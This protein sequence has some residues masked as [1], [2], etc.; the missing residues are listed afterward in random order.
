MV[1]AATGFIACVG[2]GA[3]QADVL[4]PVPDV[5]PESTLLVRGT[6]D[7]AGALSNDDQMEIVSRV[8]MEFYYPTDRQARWLDPRPLAHLRSAA[9]DD[10][11]GSDPDF[12]DEAVTGA[13]NSRICVLAH[14]DFGCRGKAGGIVRFS[15]PYR[16]AKDTAVVFAYYTPRDSLGAAGKPQPEMQFKMKVNSDGDW[17]MFAKALVNKQQGQR[18]I[19]RPKP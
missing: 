6:A 5:A 17:V 7:A 12:A 11:V 18:E 10:T 2:A 16:V 13:G 9:A 15:W 8:L 4:I 14:R 19:P 3:R 1:L